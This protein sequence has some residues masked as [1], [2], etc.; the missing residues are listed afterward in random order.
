MAGESSPKVVSLDDQRATDQRL[1]GAKAAALATAAAHGLP[2][3]PGFVLTTAATAPGEV[4][5]AVGPEVRAAWEKLSDGGRRSLVVRSSST[6]ED[7]AGSSMAGRFESVVG[8]NGWDAFQAAVRT[9]LDSRRHAAEGVADLTGDEP[10]AVLVQPLV[11]STA[12]GVLFGVDPVSGRTD[13]LV[14][15]ASTEGPDAVVSGKVEGSRYVIDRSG[16]EV[17]ADHGGGGARLEG[18]QLS[19]LAELA[20]TAADIFGGHQDVEWAFDRQ[21]NLALLQSRPV[22]TEVAGV[23]CGPILG[24]GPVS[25]TFPEPL[26]AL[27]QDL[28]V[29]P[30]REALCQALRLAGA[31]TETELAASPV[32]VC[33]GGRV[34]IDLELTGVVPRRSP[35]SRLDPRPRLRRLRAAWRVGRLRAALPGL[36]DDVVQQTDTALAA[37]PDLDSLSDRQLLAVLDRG[38]AA[39]VA[40]HAHE[41]LIG[42]L[43]AP[44]APRLTG[45][46]VALRVLAHAR[47][48]GTPDEEIIAR[49]PVVLALSPPRISA[50][51]PL[52]RPV[53][54][55]PWR[56]ERARDHDAVLREALRLRARWLQE[57][58]ARV[59]WV[60]G[61]RLAD[62]GVLDDPELVRRF[63]RDDLQGIVLGGTEPTALPGQAEAGTSEPL[64]AR[65]RLS[66]AGR[67]IPMVSGDEG[68]GTGA[69]GGVGRG[70]VVHDVADAKDGSVLVV[71]N[72]DPSI[73]PILPRLAGLVAETGSVL[74]HI[75]ILAREANLPTVVGFPGA[76]DKFPPGARVA[77]DGSEGDVEIVDDQ[78]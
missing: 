23:P 32:V 44:D 62:R 65:F 7:L 56:P 29:A 68:A 53:E 31:A 5:G 30:L 43:V 8:V 54:P 10:L 16:D 18:S 24:P 41:V 51:N 77:V 55:P 37:V 75:A 13:Q 26:A 72:L 76:I 57:L 69:G 71:R 63:R 22:T 9:V 58:T 19:A 49:H 17:Q 2:V 50:G 14:V 34:A 27:E 25:E 73:A 64:P 61:E 20:G 66:D 21:G 59:A 35:P 60:L 47:Q 70:V 4:A 11:D 74:A 38:S 12:G 45:T 52:P 3:L 78:R 33:I 39:L 40:A 6:V 42:Q 1:T 15:A 36:A 46:S 67:P 28:W 48:R